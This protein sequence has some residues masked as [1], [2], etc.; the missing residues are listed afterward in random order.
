MEPKRVAILFMF[1][2]LLLTGFLFYFLVFVNESLTGKIIL[3]WSDEHGCLTHQ[4]YTWN[5]T[6]QACVR[7]WVSQNQSSRYQ[8]FSE[9]SMKNSLNNTEINWTTN[10]N[11]TEVSGNSGSVNSTGGNK[12]INLTNLS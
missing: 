11:V 3:N 7:E 12:T 5:A 4:G 1:G 10:V 6:E 2:M 9:I 8:N